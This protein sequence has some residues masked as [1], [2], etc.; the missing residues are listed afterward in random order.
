MMQPLQRR[1][2]MA[3]SGATGSCFCH[4][5][6]SCAVGDQGT[7]AGIFRT[8]VRPLCLVAMLSTCGLGFVCEDAPELRVSSTCE[9]RKGLRT[10]AA[11][12][13]QSKTRACGVL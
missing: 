2:E 13:L 12:V 1:H 9:T 7:H 11:C 6:G 5:H 10:R 4:V 8:V 3:S